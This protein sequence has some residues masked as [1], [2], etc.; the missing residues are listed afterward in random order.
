MRASEVV[1]GVQRFW[2]PGADNNAFLIS[3]AETTLIDCG[4]PGKGLPPEAFGGVRHVVV[5]HCH[6]DHT[7]RLATVSAATGATVYAH[8]AD[9]TIIRTGAERPRGQPSA[10][11]G[12]LMLAMAPRASRADAAAVHVEIHDRQELPAAGGLRC[13]STPGHTSGHMSFLWP[14]RGGVLFVGDAAA[15]MFRRL[16]I[17]PINEDTVAARESFA[18][19]AGLEFATAC[20]GHGSPIRGRA[21]SRFRRALELFAAP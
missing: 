14:H 2:F 17:A 4:P 3:D 8:A 10:W 18:K 6:T 19:L 16:D 21:A 1:S 13:I 5:T 20:F 11:L 7:G 12:R 9:A 15:N